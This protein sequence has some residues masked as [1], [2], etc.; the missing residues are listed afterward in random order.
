MRV[1]EI[2]GDDYAMVQF[3]DGV[4]AGFVDPERLWNASGKA[5]TSLEF[6]DTDSSGDL[7]YFEYRAHEFGE[8]DPKFIDFMLDEI[9][10]YGGL[11][12]HGFYIIGDDV[13]HDD[14]PEP[15]TGAML[16]DQG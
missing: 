8:V 13:I 5:G 9:C 14:G 11:K 10:D 7:T 4:E 16:E 6:S 15:Y 1:L 2:Y 3:Y 12:H